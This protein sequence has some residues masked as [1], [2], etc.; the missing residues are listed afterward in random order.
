MKKFFKI[1]LFIAIFMIINIFQLTSFA[2]NKVIVLDPGH[3]GKDTGA[4]NEKAG[5]V[6]RDINL[7][8]ANYL[9]E[10]L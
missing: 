3:G 2:A 5:L 1:I 10:Y 8:T 6:E 4:I 7:K 9:K